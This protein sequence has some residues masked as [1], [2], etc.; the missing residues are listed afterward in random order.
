MTQ[1]LDGRQLA[2]TIKDEMRH[3][4]SSLQTLYGR[5]PCLKVVRVGNDP[6]SHTYVNSKIRAT[7]YVGMDHQLVE[8]PEDCTEDELL[9]L[10]HEMNNDDAV[11]GILV[12]VPLPSHIAEDRVIAAIAAAK[13]VDGFHP[14]N[15]AK[16]WLYQPCVV[17]CTPL[18][19]IEMLDRYQIPVMGKRVVVIG[20]SNYVGNPVA[21]MLLDRKALVTLAYDT[22]PL[23]PDVCRQ[24]D[25][26]IVTVGI[27]NMLTSE[28]V[29]PG[30]VVMDVGNN[31]MEDGTFVGDVDWASVSPIASAITPVPGGVG[32]MIIAMLLRN[33]IECFVERMKAQTKANQ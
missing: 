24:A 15:V 19:I 17:P 27:P 11:D 1:L 23:L 9:A 14:E 20:K 3:E 18:G 26:V 21:K 29:R 2:Q 6:A 30:A 33:T 8:L 25:I 31:L 32:P 22:T 10:V 5:K 16:L 13:D 7:E 12:Q 4:I 28:Y